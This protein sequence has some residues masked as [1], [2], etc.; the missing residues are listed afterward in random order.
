MKARMMMT[1]AMLSGLSSLLFP[2]TAPA[3][4]FEKPLVSGSMVW[5]GGHSQ[6]GVSVSSGGGDF[7]A[8]MRMDAWRNPAPP[9]HAKPPPPDRS[10][11]RPSP[12]PPPDRS[13][14]PSQPPP[15]DRP[16][17]RPTPPPDRPW[18]PSQP[19]PPP[20]HGK[21]L[22]P[23]WVNP[24]WPPARVPIYVSKPPPGIDYWDSRW[25]TDPVI[26]Y[27]ESGRRLYQPRLRGHV[28][29]IQIWSSYNQTWVTIGEHP[30][31]W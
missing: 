5:K 16:W 22:P 13:W 28:A 27:L 25:P 15:P 1:C 20:D 8:G 10:G 19:P 21:M 7:G 11:P 4:A 26:V 12:P 29:F 3:Q 18:P 24:P 31:I 2:G 14:S 6:G 30:S 23:D 17:P 9:P